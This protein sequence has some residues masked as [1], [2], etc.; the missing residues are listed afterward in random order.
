VRS[1]SIGNVVVYWRLGMEAVND[2]YPPLDGSALFLDVIISL[3][4]FVACFT[5]AQCG[6][7][8]CMS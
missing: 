6:L 7:F 2:F 5:T 4:S 3:Q 8:L 1:G